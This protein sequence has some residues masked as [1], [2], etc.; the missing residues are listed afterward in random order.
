MVQTDEGIFQFYLDPVVKKPI[1][2]GKGA[3]INVPVKSLTT[4]FADMTYCNYPQLLLIFPERQTQVE[5]MGKKSTQASHQELHFENI[6]TL[7]PHADNT[8]QQ[9]VSYTLIVFTVFSESCGRGHYKVYLQK[10]K[11]RMVRVR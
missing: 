7:K 1:I 4:Y 11:H 9:E 3:G 8:D 2:C 5:T 10:R 6:I